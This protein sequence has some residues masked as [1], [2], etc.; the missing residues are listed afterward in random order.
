MKK[1]S[2]FALILMGSLFICGNCPAARAQGQVYLF[3]GSQLDNG[4]AAALGFHNPGS[5]GTHFMNGPTYGE[6]LPGLLGLGFEASNGYAYGG[7]TSGTGNVVGTAFN[8][9]HY[10]GLQ[11]QISAAAAAGLRFTPSDLILINAAQDDFIAEEFTGNP[12]TTAT[13]VAIG[14]TIATNSATAVL[15]SNALGG[16]NFVVATPWDYWQSPDH[17]NF[18][19]DAI[20][21]GVNEAV[22]QM[23]P[24]LQ[25]VHNATGD[26]IVIYNSELAFSQFIASPAAYGFTNTTVGCGTDQTCLNGAASHYLF[27][28]SNHPTTY[29]QQIIAEQIANLELAPAQAA[30]GVQLL[31]DETN[32]FDHA[33]RQ[34]IDQLPQDMQTM[35]IFFTGV[36]GFGTQSSLTAP[37]GLPATFNG[38]YR[39]SGGAVG[40][41]GSPMEGMAAGGLIG[42]A[43]M[44]ESVAGGEHLDGQSVLFGLFTSYRMGDWRFDGAA[45]YSWD[46]FNQI[47]RPGVMLGNLT[48]S[49]S[50]YGLSTTG[51]VSRRFEFAPLAIIPMV[52]LSYQHSSLSSYTEHGDPLLAQQI[53]Q[54]AVNG[55]FGD[56][57]G[58]V[59]L[60]R[61]AGDLLLMPAVTVLAEHDFLGSGFTVSS[62]AM[63]API[64]RSLEVP[65]AGQNYGRID[66]SLTSQ[67]G[68]GII[69]SVS[70]FTTVWRNA[71]NE[72]GVQLI[73]QI[74]L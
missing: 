52:A 71:G 25:T 3:G 27:F 11:G 46:S 13:A 24:A 33:I 63:S 73:L 35:H 45:A 21:A 66:V 58:T 42:A 51:Q 30:S 59:E 39:I 36:N 8:N 18:P 1:I 55:F 26:D 44:N 16:R 62:A 23:V 20:T 2:K 43:N 31:A 56:A 61:P 41:E 12:L 64:T 67:L 57:G 19:S 74:P 34:H 68:K 48:A 54:T 69:A 32:L 15:R 9:P 60:Q 65:D 4:N 6:Y 29:T 40:L 72:H 10:L 47:S 50:G 22:Q 53:G 14:N 7:A 5:D 38:N 49:P 37:N 70:M 28:D 17:G